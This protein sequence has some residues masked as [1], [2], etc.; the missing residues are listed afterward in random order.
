MRCLSPCAHP[1]FPPGDTHTWAWTQASASLTWFE[2]VLQV[3]LC[4]GFP[5]FLPL[6]SLLFLHPG[7]FSSFSHLPSVQHFGTLILLSFPF[8]PLPQI[9]G[10][11]GGQVGR[12]SG[13]WVAQGPILHPFPQASSHSRRHWDLCG[14]L[15]SVVHEHVHPQA[16][17]KFSSPLQ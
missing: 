5:W 15:R 16:P 14:W 11:A 8:P 12:G 13:Q 3:P 6:F 10:W 2:H 4:Q 9:F 1:I 17:S 7:V